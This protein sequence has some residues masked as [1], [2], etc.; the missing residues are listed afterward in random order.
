MG[1]V[2][3]NVKPG[4]LEA[5][6]GDLPLFEKVVVSRLNSYRTSVRRFRALN[7]TFRNPYH[8][9]FK[10][11]IGSPF[12]YIGVTKDGRCVPLRTRAEVRLVSSSG[13]TPSRV[14]NL[15]VSE[16]GVTSFDYEFEG[17]M[18]RI[19]MNGLLTNGDP[20]VFVEDEYQFLPVKGR[21]VVD[22]GASVGDSAIYFA[23]R[24]ARVVFG[25]EP[26]PL[27]F[28]T[29]V[30]NIVLNGLER[31]IRLVRAAI[32]PVNGRVRIDTSSQDVFSSIQGSYGGLATEVLTLADI[33]EQQSVEGG[34]LKMDC[35][36]AE[37]GVLSNSSVDTLRSFSHMQIE[38]HYGSRS[39]E[40]VLAHAGFKVSRSGPERFAGVRGNAAMHFG[41][42]YATQQ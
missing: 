24:G 2:G 11:I 36:G 23:V 5:H 41:F 31:R 37:Y 39:L 40:R 33:V 38:Y 9:L 21:T 12:P 19:K 1:G 42:I 35:E 15:T 8:L 17:E 27:T 32:G 28:Q 14:S 4:G 26:F 29:G 34:I 3:A 25:Y 10:Y 30:N 6:L 18:V 22:V 20:G 7:R 13:W 16:S